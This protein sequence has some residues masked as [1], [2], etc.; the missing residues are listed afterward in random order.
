MTAEYGIFDAEGL[1][2]GGFYNSEKAAERAVGEPGTYAAL[3][4]VS[5]VDQ[6]HDDC[7]ECAD[8]D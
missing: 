5:H 7:E 1:I 8:D 2:E 4:C 6:P 3:V